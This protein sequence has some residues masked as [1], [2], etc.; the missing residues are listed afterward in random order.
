ML[1]HYST[2]EAKAKGKKKLYNRSLKTT[3]TRL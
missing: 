3:T 1:G 2:D